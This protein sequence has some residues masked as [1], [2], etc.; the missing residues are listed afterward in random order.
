MDLV[1]EGVVWIIRWQL[2]V[3][4]GLPV[5]VQP[6]QPPII[7]AGQAQ[8]PGRLPSGNVVGQA[9]LRFVVVLLHRLHPRIPLAIFPWYRSCDHDLHT[10][11]YHVDVLIPPALTPNE[12]NIRLHH[13][14]ANDWRVQ[15]VIC[16]GLVRRRRRNTVARDARHHDG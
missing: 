6:D 11:S 8:G 15:D 7:T 1:N 10:C 12:S 3:P 5:P 9:T 2:D 13:R 14:V 16:T 4:L